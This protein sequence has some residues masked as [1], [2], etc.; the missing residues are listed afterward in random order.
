M[1]DLQSVVCYRWRPQHADHRFVFG[2]ETVNTLKAMVRRFYTRPVRFIC[3][4]DDPSGLDPDVEVVPIWDDY[5]NLPSPHGKRNP[6]CYRR[7]KGFSAEMASVF[8]QRFVT[9]DLD[10]VATGDLRTIF[11]RPEEF[12][13][14]GDTN[15]Q[16]HS[17]YNGSLML[18]TAGCRSQVWERFDPIRSPDEAYR[19]G[20]YGS[21]QAIISHCLGPNEA[22][23]MRSD[24]VYSFRNDFVLKSV[25]A[26]PENA[27]LVIF[28]GRLKPWM[29]EVTDRYPWVRQHWTAEA[30]CT[31]A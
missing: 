29:P 4:T 26:L 20:C 9:V 27:R 25:R 7:L 3:C 17:Y 1:P 12:V 21:D 24:G 16:P 10:C 30:T 19:A 31:A 13:A 6:S 18:M 2:A 8:G 28:H 5:A 11:D 22:K 23:F 15:P 14:Y